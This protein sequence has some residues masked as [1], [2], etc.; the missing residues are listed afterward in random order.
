[1]FGM[2]SRLITRKPRVKKMASV[3][4][5]TAKIKSLQHGQGD[6][7]QAWLHPKQRQVMAC[8]QTTS[9]ITT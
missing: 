6:K 1:M 5:D 7:N 4:K 2:V 8:I 3:S 9:K